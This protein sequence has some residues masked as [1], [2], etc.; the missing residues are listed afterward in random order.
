MDHIFEG[1][2]VSHLCELHDVLGL[3]GNDLDGQT[4][5]YPRTGESAPHT[6]PSLPSAC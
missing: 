2:A 1:G 3:C 4:G 5:V 6:P